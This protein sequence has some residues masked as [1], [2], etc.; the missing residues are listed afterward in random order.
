MERPV[1]G[2]Y[3]N[4]LCSCCMEKFKNVSY[5]VLDISGSPTGKGICP[6]CMARIK[7]A[8][9]RKEG[10]NW[11]NGN[12]DPSSHVGKGFIGQQIIAKTY[13]VEDC[14]LKMNSFHFYIDL[15]KITGYGYGEI[16]TAT[17]KKYGEYWS[18]SCMVKECDTF[19]LVCLDEYWPWRD[20]K[21][22][23]AVPCWE[24][25]G[26]SGVYIRENFRLSRSKWK[27]LEEFRI[28]EKPFNSTFHNM[29]LENCKILRRC[30]DVRKWR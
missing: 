6:T 16:K 17:F 24:V 18:F 23:Y 12:L 21:R 26:G 28:D 30:E 29:K 13:G 10:T 20:V 19:F 2:I 8:E 11:R 14:N 3:I 15:N 4:D 7:N 5:D 25:F 22:V 27:Y 9:H 1:N